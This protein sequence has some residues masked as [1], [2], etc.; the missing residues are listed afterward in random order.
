MSAFYEELYR[1]RDRLIVSVEPDSE[2]SCFRAY[3][4]GEIYTSAFVSPYGDKR[5]SRG[6]RNGRQMRMRTSLP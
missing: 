3:C 6:G 1:G 2:G 4:G 5:Q